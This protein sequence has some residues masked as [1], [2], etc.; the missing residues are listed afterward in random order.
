[1]NVVSLLGRT[2]SDIELKTTPSGVS[3]CSFT[4]A[5]DRRY[6]P[7][8]Q[9]R[10]TDFI[11]CVAWRSNAEFLSKWFRKGDS[12]AVTGELQTRQY[13]DKNGNKRTATEVVVDN[14]YFAGSKKQE[15][16]APVQ[17][18]Q[19][20]PFQQEQSDGGFEELFPDGDDLPF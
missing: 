3:V 17:Q 18:G 13:T 12:L 1:M 9:E 4:I 15:Q 2:T 5:V 14:A 11:N 10:Q 16:G 20:V 19:V 8:G 7:K 6:T